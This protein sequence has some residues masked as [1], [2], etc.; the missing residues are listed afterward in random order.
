MRT[1]SHVSQ[2]LKVCVCP[3]F[4]SFMSSE[5]MG[6]RKFVIAGA[7]AFA[8]VASVAAIGVPAGWY[9]RAN[10]VCSCEPASCAARP[11]RTSA[12]RQSL[13]QRPTLQYRRECYSQNDSSDEAA[14]A[15][16]RQREKEKEKAKAREEKAAALDS[17]CAGSTS[18]APTSASDAAKAWSQRRLP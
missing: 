12:R 3:S 1:R 18:A 17:A 14:Q 16:K 7:V 6:K 2:N 5:S 10:S 15:A 9:S 4:L 8:V 11:S 13:N